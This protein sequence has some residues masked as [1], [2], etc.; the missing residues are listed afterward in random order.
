MFISKF[1][2]QAYFAAVLGLVFGAN[3]VAKAAKEVVVK[4]AVNGVVVTVPSVTSNKF[5][6]AANV[7]GFVTT[8]N[9]LVTANGVEVYSNLKSKI[10]A[11]GVAIRSFASWL[12][13]NGKA[14]KNSVVTV[15]KKSEF[16]A[17]LNKIAEECKKAVKAAK[18]VAKNAKTKRSVLKAQIKAIK[19]QF[20]EAAKVAESNYVAKLVAAVRARIAKAQNEVVA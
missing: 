5:A 10:Y 1:S 11:N 6:K 18:E 8:K 16:R 12:V 4:D 15:E 20:A 9:L 19:A 2:R 17:I 7:V 13:V 14:V 3:V